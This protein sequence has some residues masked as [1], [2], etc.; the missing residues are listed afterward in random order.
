MSKV[1]QYNIPPELTKPGMTFGE[2][3]WALGMMALLI[4]GIMS[5]GIT[6]SNNDEIL[7]QRIDA[8][9]DLHVECVELRASADGEN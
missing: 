4:W 3:F 5:V 1:R 7:K 9:C 8:L 6:S 2:T